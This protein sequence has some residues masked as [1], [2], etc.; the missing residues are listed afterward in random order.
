M[1]A[2]PMRLPHGFT[3]DGTGDV[4]VLS[5]HMVAGVVSVGDRWWH[6]GHHAGRPKHAGLYTGSGWRDRLMADACLHLLRKA[7]TA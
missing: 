1:T 4:Q 3:L 6:P 5:Y 7:C 2:S